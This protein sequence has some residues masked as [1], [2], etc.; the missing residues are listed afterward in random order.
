V[1]SN[2]GH[3]ESGSGIAG[4]IKVVLSLERGIIPPMSENFCTLNPALDLDYLNLKVGFATSS[5]HII[6]LILFSLYLM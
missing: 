2:I 5:T 1:K 6:R 3:L 4:L